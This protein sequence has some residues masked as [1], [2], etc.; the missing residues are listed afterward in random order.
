MK[1]RIWIF[2]LIC[3]TAVWY[4]KEAN[5]D[6]GKM[7]IYPYDWGSLLPPEPPH[8]QLQGNGGPINNGQEKFDITNNNTNV[9]QFQN[10]TL[11]QIQALQQQLADLRALINEL[12]N[13]PKVTPPPTRDDPPGPTEPLPPPPGTVTDNG[14]GFVQA[15][16]GDSGSGLAGYFDEP[17]QQAVIAWNGREDQYGRET[18][19][20]T[21]NEESGHGPGLLLSVLPLP[22]KPERVKQARQQ[23]FT[24]AKTLFLSKTPVPPSGAGQAGVIL[25]S[26]IGPHNVFVWQL[27]NVKTFQKDV[28]AWVANR[29]NGQAA[30]LI[31]DDTVRVLQYY[32]ERGFRYFA[33]D[34]TEVKGTESTKVAIAYTFQSSQI[35]YPLVISRIGGT[36]T[37]STVDLIIMSP[38]KKDAGGNYKP[39]AI[40]LT[41]AIKKVISTGK[42]ALGDDEAE[43]V[44]GGT[45]SFSI[46]EVRRIDPSLDVFNGSVDYVTVRNIKFTKLLNQYT[47]DFTAKNPD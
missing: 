21:T 17:A 16:P 7:W 39:G 35:Y 27:D 12:R 43:L 8:P 3:C 9:I 31:T 24:D 4:S 47:K 33:F 32:F 18:L 11:T 26:K 10:E 37:W 28:Q 14:L 44:N 19:V 40:K 15:D 25:E 45:V 13:E 29:F 5:A 36:G 34:L 20:L 41:G 30:A 42:P 38:V 46:D 23:A 2:A 22:G 6:C 1:L